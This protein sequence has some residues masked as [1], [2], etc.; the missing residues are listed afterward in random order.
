ML[1]PVNTCTVFCMHAVVLCP[2]PP[3]ERMLGKV[4][5]F[6]FKK[7][8]MTLLLIR[9][10]TLMLALFTS[11][12]RMELISEQTERSFRLQLIYC[13]KG[14]VR[15]FER[16][17]VR[18]QGRKGA[19]LYR[20]GF[21]TSIYLTFSRHRHRPISHTE[22]NRVGSRENAKIIWKYKFEEFLESNHKAIIDNFLPA[23]TA[24]TGK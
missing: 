4:I 14:R 2:A 22:V 9:S 13:W 15:R 16:P 10:S 6:V 5:W 19:G 12:D 24:L 20:E 1:L 23:L 18:Q 11:A 3:N 7:L 8:W 21:W 17:R